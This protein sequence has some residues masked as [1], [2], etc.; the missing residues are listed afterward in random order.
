M[1]FIIC[2]EL[3]KAHPS[4]KTKSEQVL[5]TIKSFGD[6]VHAMESTWFVNSE[7]TPTQIF[8]ALEKITD[9]SDRIWVDKITSAHQGYIQDRAVKPNT[10]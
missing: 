8:S 10:I 3:N 9:A 5:K 2:Y 6:C 1:I 4:Y 7:L